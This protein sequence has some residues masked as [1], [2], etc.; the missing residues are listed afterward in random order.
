MA[1]IRARRKRERGSGP[2]QCQRGG[3]AMVGG[4][5]S[6]SMITATA[7]EA[8][9]REIKGMGRRRGTRRSLPSEKRRRRRLGDDGLRLADAGE[10][11]CYGCGSVSGTGAGRGSRRSAE[12]GSTLFYMESE[13]RGAPTSL[14]SWARAV[15]VP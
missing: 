12:T 5:R 11:R 13:A 7:L 10:R 15:V 9:I 3:A 1:L 14:R 8:M 6:S 2:E 4:E